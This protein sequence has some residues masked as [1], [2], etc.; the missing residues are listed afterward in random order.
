MFNSRIRPYLF[1]LLFIT[2]LP[3]L[4]YAGRNLQPKSQEEPA[5]SA[6]DSIA[7]VAAQRPV[8]NAVYWWRT[9]FDP[10]SLELQFL[11]D[12]HIGR[13][14]VR[15]FDMV[16]DPANRPEPI[17]PNATLQFRRPLPDTLEIVPTIYITNE[18]M[19]NWPKEPSEYWWSDGARF[20]SMSY[21]V[22]QLVYRIKAMNKRNGVTPQVHEVQVDCDWSTSTRQTFFNFCDSL[23]QRLHHEGMIL[24][25]TIRLHQLRQEAPPVDRCVLMCYNTGALRSLSTHNSILDASDVYAYL[26]ER[27]LHDFPLPLDVAYP[28][29]GWS[30]MYR[31]DHSFAGIVR[32]T[33]LNDKTMFRQ[34]S[35]SLYE[36]LHDCSAGHAFLP[37]GNLLRREVVDFNTV[38]AVKSQIDL[39]FS[40]SQ[41]QPS[42]ILYHLDASNLQHYTYDQLESL[43][44]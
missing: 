19:A 39:K 28:T 32:T 9:V 4:F 38:H 35:D 36:V 18:V 6:A 31:P 40:H 42:V 29:F 15:Y 37:K 26:K 34:R 33:D 22:D 27:D 12:H 21:Y 41:F 24:S 30:V 44:Q 5:F 8:S 2:A 1:L 43:Y 13:M 23:R 14:Y 7:R 17:V 11:S 10:D 3:A 20:K 16:Y 25:A